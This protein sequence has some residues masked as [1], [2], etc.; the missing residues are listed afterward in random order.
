MRLSLEA[1]L[2]WGI[3]V[4][5]STINTALKFGPSD[6]DGTT[7]M[8]STTF[9]L[10]CM[11]QEHKHQNCLQITSLAISVMTGNNIFLD[12]STSNEKRD[13]QEQEYIDERQCSSV[14]SLNTEVEGFWFKNFGYAALTEVSQ[15]HQRSWRM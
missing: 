4:S 15:V 5:K 1:H 13:Y 7:S 12:F 9:C 3:G 6:L 8:Y 10:L 2:S 11:G 14:Y